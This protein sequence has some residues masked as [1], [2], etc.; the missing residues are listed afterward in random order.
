MPAQSTAEPVATGLRQSEALAFRHVNGLLASAGQ[1]PHAR[2]IALHRT[3]QLWSLL[4][5]DL[6]SPGNALP[7]TLRCTLTSLGLW[8]QRESMARIGTDASLD[9]IIALHRDLIEGLESQGW[10]DAPAHAA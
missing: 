1:A 8:A 5:A 6:T 4:L 2:T 3:H 9:P 10:I 7:T